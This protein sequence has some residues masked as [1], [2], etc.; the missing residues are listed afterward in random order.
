MKNVSAEMETPARKAK[1]SV[2]L[3]NRTHWY[4]YVELME[5]RRRFVNQDTIDGGMQAADWEGIQIISVPNLATGA[6][7]FLD[8]RYW[9][10]YILR[11]FEVKPKDSGT[12]S[13]LFI[14]TH[15][16]QLVCK[17][18]GRQAAITDLST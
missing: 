4:Q 10:Y 8:E 7:Y 5:D 15:Y 9:S 2:V 11:D 13:D 3:T 18:P 1:V 14:I 12:D 6:M 17:H 16:S